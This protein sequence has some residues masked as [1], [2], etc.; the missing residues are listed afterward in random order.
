MMIPNRTFRVPSGAMAPT[1]Q[2]GEHVTASLDPSSTPQIGD[3]VVFHPPAGADPANAVCGDSRQ[4]AGHSEACSRP[5]PQ[6]SSQ[7]Y[8]KRI[9]AGPGDTIAITNGYVIRNGRTENEP[10]VLQP[11]R[12][13]PRN[14]PPWIT[15]PPSPALNFPTPIT[16][17]PDHYFV[18]GDNRAESDD[19]R[20]WGP[21]PRAWIIGTIN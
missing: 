10:Y 9:V 18:L 6:R 1:L 13:R 15:L 20:Y 21:V 14:L 11:H 3:I 16:I 2:L 4:G 5:T 7:T 12:G 19:S 8:I 17:P